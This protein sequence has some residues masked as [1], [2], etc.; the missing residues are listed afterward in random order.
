MP[1]NRGNHLTCTR[2][3]SEPTRV[4]LIT[5]NKYANKTNDAI[6]TLY[7]K[8]TVMDQ[9]WQIDQ[10]YKQKPETKTENQKQ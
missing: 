7:T 5:A 10:L 4:I 9:Q 6:I 3:S 2:L 8:M 1:Q